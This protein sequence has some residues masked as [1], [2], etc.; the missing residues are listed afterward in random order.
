MCTQIN[1]EKQYGVEGETEYEKQTVR[2]E[3]RE[4]GREGCMREIGIVPLKIQE[5]ILS[6]EES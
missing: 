6:K 2:R 1:E 5:K 3:K 4:D